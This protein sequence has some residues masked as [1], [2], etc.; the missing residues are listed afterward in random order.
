MHVEEPALRPSVDVGHSASFKH[1][2]GDLGT[3]SNDQTPIAQFKR[4][5]RDSDSPPPGS[6]PARTPL[7]DVPAVGPR[8]NLPFATSSMNLRRPVK[9]TCESSYSARWLPFGHKRKRPCLTAPAIISM[10]FGSIVS[11]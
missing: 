9:Y 2:I 10:Y 11:F 1:V 6:R 7:A 4:G 5:P 8:Q 3:L